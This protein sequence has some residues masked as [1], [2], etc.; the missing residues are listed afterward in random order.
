[1]AL[2]HENVEVKNVSGI[3]QTSDSKSVEMVEA[4]PAPPS[5]QIEGS[6]ENKPGSAAGPGT[7][8]KISKTTE[9][10]LQN[11]VDQHNEKMKKDGKPSH[12]RTTLAQLKSVYRRGAGAYSSSHRPGVSRAA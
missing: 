5:E 9:K 6:D 7:D 8:I 1:M 12:T 10:A 3:G 2:T 4:Q 11:K